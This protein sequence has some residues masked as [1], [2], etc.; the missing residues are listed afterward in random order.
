MTSNSIG[1]ITVINRMHPDEW[2]GDQVDE[3]FRYLRI[4]GVQFITREVPEAA[5]RSRG[6][7]P[8]MNTVHC[9]PGRPNGNRDEQWAWQVTQLCRDSVL[10]LDIHGALADY[11]GAYAFTSSGNWSNPLVQGV[12]SLLDTDWCVLFP[13]PFA[14]AHLPNYIGVDLP[15]SATFLRD[16][17]AYLARLARGWRPKPRD[18][19]PY[20]FVRAVQGTEARRAGLSR[21]YKQLERLPDDAARMLGL[22]VPAHAFDWDAD[23]LEPIAGVWGEVMTP[24]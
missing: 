22:P 17:P 5:M 14:A 9:F 3:M 4:P 12:S 8:G 21:S 19:T 7:E 15:Q 2:P 1:K 23:T 13:K 11:G 24:A 6:I 20:R 16:L 10:T 18:M